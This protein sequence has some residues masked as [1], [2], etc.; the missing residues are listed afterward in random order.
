MTR[1][2]T[3]PDWQIA[4]VQTPTATIPSW[5]GQLG[6]SG[7]ALWAAALTIPDWTAAGAMADGPFVLVRE[8]TVAARHSF[9]PPKKLAIAA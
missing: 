5:T 3:I 9:E 8:P 2:R 7:R 1:T 4:V 6:G